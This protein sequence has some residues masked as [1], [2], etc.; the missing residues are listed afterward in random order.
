MC[1]CGEANEAAKKKSSDKAGSGKKPCQQTKKCKIVKIETTINAAGNRIYMN[2]PNTKV[3]VT[4]V[5]TYQEVESEEGDDCC[6]KVVFSFEDPAPANTSKDDSFEYQTGKFLGKRGDA[7]AIYWEAHAEHAA[8]SADSFNATTKVESKPLTGKANNL[9]AKV[10]LKPSGVGGN[11]YEVKGIVYKPDG[12]TE[13]TSDKAPKATVW[14]KIDFNAY[15]MTG[16][17][18]VSTHGTTAVMTGYFTN[19]TYVKYTLGTVTMIAAAHS[20][21][22][23]G[24]WDHGTSAQLNWATHRAK[25]VAETPTA[26]ETTKSNATPADAAARTAIQD[27]ADAWRDRINTAYRSGLNNWASDAGVPVN[28]LVAIEH[29]HPKY[30]AAAPNADSVTNEWSAFPWLRITVEGISIHPDR[31]WINGQGLSYG[32][33]AYITAGMSAARTK[34]GIAHEAG[35]ESKNQFKRKTFGGG[36]HSA[37]AG[38]MDPVGSLSSF[39][40]TE[41]EVLRGFK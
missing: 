5:V 33:R 26:D 22:Y 23:I 19:D 29:E 35:H 14:R 27:K 18:H 6:P 15:E 2:D 28:S 39:T 40:A 20:V 25:T 32:Q 4:A 24:L 12:T 13:I 17:A 36:D 37:A 7:S 21:R 1:Q 34:V 38:L 16:Q 8:T 10:W 9:I 31:R 41:K 11:D 3:L 30:S